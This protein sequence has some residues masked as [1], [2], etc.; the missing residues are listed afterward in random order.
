MTRLLGLLL[1]ARLGT[2]FR[3][4]VAS[5]WTS[6]LGDGFALAAGPLLVASQTRDPTLVALATLLQRLPWL[7]F[8]IPAGVLADR[9]GRSA[10]VATVDVART[11]VLALLALAIISGR[12]DIAIVLAALFVLG[13]AEVF[14]NTAMAALPPLLVGRGDLVLANA[15]LQTGLVVVFQLVGPPVGAALFALSVPLPFAAQALLVAL[16]ALFIVRVRAGT[17][18][19]PATTA[20][21]L[22]GD[23]VEGLRWVRHNAPVRTLVLTILTFNVTFGAAWSVLVLYARERLGMDAVGFGL[24]TTALAVGGIAGTGS[25]G[26]IT[27]RVSLFNLMRVGLVIETFTHLALAL[28][29]RPLVALLVM[30]VFGAHAFIWGTTSVTVRQRAVPNELQGRVGSINS[31]ATFTGIVVGSALGGPI[32]AR[33]GI[34]AP[35]WFAFAGSAVF[36]VAIWRELAHIAHQDQL[37]EAAAAP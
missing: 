12:V 28:T 22:R 5:S 36:V 29:T 34:T 9:R 3:W 17:P 8:A 35:F 14:G 37:T 1:P 21:R 33:W 6:N 7:L 13:T 24:L 11:A 32:A 16:G 20:R 26:W 2:R 18:S 27:Q 4:L 10:I 25:Y 30:V 15:R 23:V 19:A 31:L